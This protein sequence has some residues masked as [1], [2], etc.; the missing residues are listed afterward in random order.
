VRVYGLDG[1][2][3]AGVAEKIGAPTLE[4]LSQPIDEIPIEGSK[5]AFRTV[6]AWG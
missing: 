4:E 3:L 2:K 6:G 1:D 5:F